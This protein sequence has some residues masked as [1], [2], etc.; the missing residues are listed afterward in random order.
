MYYQINCSY[1]NFNAFP[2]KWN[3]HQDLDIIN[4]FQRGHEK[5][6]ISPKCYQ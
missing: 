6:M 2:A 4:E 3:N 1:S 5:A